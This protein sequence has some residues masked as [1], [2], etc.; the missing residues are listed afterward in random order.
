MIYVYDRELNN[1][2][3]QNPRKITLAYQIID[4][5]YSAIKKTS[6]TEAQA[7]GYSV[8]GMMKNDINP[9]YDLDDTFKSLSL[10]EKLPEK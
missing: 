7:V 10:A 2:L 9:E 5:I 6:D 4:S 3:N 1:S 8:I